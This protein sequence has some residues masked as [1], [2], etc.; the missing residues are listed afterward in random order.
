M[1]IKENRPKQGMLCVGN[2]TEHFMKNLVK[3][4]TILQRIMQNNEEWRIFASKIRGRNIKV[5]T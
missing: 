2:H 1:Y 4:T 3:S 5:P